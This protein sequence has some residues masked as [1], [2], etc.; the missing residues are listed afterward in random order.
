M[1][2]GLYLEYKQYCDNEGMDE[3]KV[4]K[5][6]GFTKAL[7][8]MGFNIYKIGQM[9]IDYYVQS[10]GGVSNAMTEEEKLIAELPF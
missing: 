3:G 9:Y 6:R 7:R 4:H 8:S 1:L 2:N 5:I 10:D